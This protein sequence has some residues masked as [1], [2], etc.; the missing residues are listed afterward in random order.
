MNH[1]SI[2]NRQAT[3]IHGVYLVAAELS[4]LGYTVAITA[5]NAAGADVMV[6]SATTAEVCSIDVKTNSKY[7]NFWLAGK[8]AKEIS[9]RSHFYAFVNI[10]T[11]D[12]REVFDYFVVPSKVVEDKTEVGKSKKGTRYFFRLRDAEAYRSKWGL[13]LGA[14]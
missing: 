1:V 14:P 7:A 4:R 8:R 3:G 5:R 2:S 6:F 12:S 11:K 9:F 10:S 13:L